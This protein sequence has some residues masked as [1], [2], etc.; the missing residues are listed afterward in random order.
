MKRYFSFSKLIILAAVS[1]LSLLLWTNLTPAMA[2]DDNLDLGVETETI[3]AFSGLSDSE[4]LDSET[5]VDIP[6]TSVMRYNYQTKLFTY[7]IAGENC[8]VTSNVADGMITTDAVTIKVPNGIL[9]SVYCNGK[10]ISGLSLTN[11]TEVG[12][13]VFKIQTKGE[14]TNLFSFQIIGAISSESS[15]FTLPEEFEFGTVLIDGEEVVP[16]GNYISMM[17]E[18]E[19]NIS[20]KCR[21]TQMPYNLQV[22]VDRTPPALKLERV[23]DGK[24]GG[25]VDISDLEEGAQI[26]ITCDGVELDYTPLLEISGTYCIIITDKAGNI[27]EYGFRLLPYLDSKSWL[28][29]ATLLVAIAA[30]VAYLVLEK[31]KLKVR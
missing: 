10:D 21:I 4:L 18:G 26:Y 9:Y 29:I 30:V 23:K 12:K 19:Y 20:Y 11:I 2:D 15:R 8:A 1:V 6:I 27:T 7:P 5:E 17:D 16:D 25:P 28:V 24:A 14:L 22:T 31:K 13:Y 3:G